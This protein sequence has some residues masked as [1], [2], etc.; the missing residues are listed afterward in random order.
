M[1]V[2]AALQQSVGF[3]ISSHVVISRPP[4][5]VLYLFE[6]QALN[7]PEANIIDPVIVVRIP[8]AFRPAMSDVALYEATR[9]VWKVGPRRENVRY[10][11]AVY[12]GMVL[13]VY[14]ILHWDRAWTGTYQTRTFED[15]TVPGRWEFVGRV[16]DAVVRDRYRGKSVRQYFSRGAQNPISYVCLPQ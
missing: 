5:S 12:Q 14:E 9:G 3:A 4:A 8:R 1:R 13:E 16:A 6:L 10:A 11:L 7:E 2:S 15:M